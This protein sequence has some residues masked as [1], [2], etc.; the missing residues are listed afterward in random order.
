MLACVA[1]TGIGA[2][3]ERADEEIIVDLRSTRARART[4]KALHDRS[5]IARQR[6]HEIA[7]RRGWPIRGIAGGRSFELMDVVEGRPRYYATDN[8]AAAI[9]TG[10]D[11]VRN[12]T[13][14]NVDGSSVIVGVWDQGAVRSTHQEFGGR[15]N[16]VDGVAA[17]FHGT[18]I[19]GTIGASGVNAAALGMASATQIDSY[20]WNSDDAEMAARGATGKGKTNDVILS[21]HSY[22]LITGWIN[23]DFSGN[24]GPHWWG[25]FPEREDRGFGIYDANASSWDAIA[26]DAPHYLIFKS[27]GNDRNDNAPGGGTYYFISNGN[28]VAATYDAGTDPFSDGYD[29]GGYDTISYRGNAKNIMTVGAVNDAVS[30]GTRS[31][32]AGTMASFSCW[33]PTDDGRIKPDIVANGI[34]LFSTD[35]DNDTDYTTLSGTSMSTPNAAGSAA[36]LADLYCK[37]FSNQVIRASTLKALIIHTADDVGNAGPDYRFGW[38]LMNTKAAADLILRQTNAASAFTITEFRFQSVNSNDT[39][40]V[41]SDGSNVLRATLAWN[42][43]AGTPQTG[44]DNRTSVL[45]NDLDLRIIAPDGSTNYPFGLDVENPANVATNGDNSIDNVE[46]VIVSAPASGLYCVS[47]SHK[48]S[49]SGGRQIYSLIISGQEANDFEVASADGLQSSGNVGGPFAPASTTYTL[50]NLGTGTV[51]WTASGCSGFTAI[52][53]SNGVITSGASTTVVVSISGNANS[54]ASGTHFDQI[55][56]TDT[57]AGVSHEREVELNVVPPP[58]PDHFTWSAITSPHLTGTAFNVTLTARD[59]LNGVQTSFN[60]EIADL[61]GF[62]TAT[63][64]TIVITELLTDTPD[65]I[66]FMNV[67]PQAVEISNWQISV[68]DDDASWPAPLNFTVP[69]GTIVP[70]GTVFTLKEFKLDSGTF[71][72]FNLGVNIFWTAALRAAVL[73]RDDVDNIIDFMCAG[74]ANPAN[75]VSPVTIPAAEW[76]SAAVAG[77]QSTVS[78]YSRTGFKD[79]DDNSDWVEAS[80]TIASANAALIVPFA[81]A[82]AISP[83]ATGPFVSGVWTG[84]IAVLEPAL[85]VYLRAEYNPDV[86]GSSDRFD[87]YTEPTADLALSKSVDDPT[88]DEAQL[89]TY[90]IALTNAGPFGATGLTVSDAVPTSVTISNTTVSQGLFTNGLWTI[91]SMFAESSAT[92]TIEATVNSNTAGF[93]V[94]NTA[95]INTVNET[96][97]AAANDSAS[98]VLIVS[99]VDV[100]VS[101]TVSSATPTEGDIVVYTVAVTNSGTDPAS[102]VIVTDAVPA[103]VT[104]SNAAPAQGTFSNGVWTIGALGAA[105]NTTLEL[106]VSINPGTGESTITNVAALTAINETDLRAI[107]NTGSVTLVVQI[108]DLELTKQVDDSNPGVGQWIEY[109]VSVSN[110]GPHPATG[111]LVDD[112]LSGLSNIVTYASTGSYTIASGAWSNVSVL[113]GAVASLTVSGQVASLTLI[114]NTAQ[115]MASDQKDP[116][117]TPANGSGAED[118]QA[119]VTVTPHFVDIGV[120]KAVDIA[121]P[122]VADLVTFTLTASNAGPE[123]ATSVVVGDALPAGLIFSNAVP[124]QGAYS[125]GA[126]SVGTLMVDSNAML[127]LSAL[128]AP[129]SG[130]LSITN[131]AVLT[132]ASPPD[133]GGGNNVAAAAVDVTSVDLDLLK[134][135]DVSQP[136]EAQLITYTLIVTNQGPDAA[137]GIKISDALPAG[138]TFSNS[139]PSQ[140]TYSNDVWDAG[141]L[142]AGQGATLDLIVR[143]DAATSGTVITN[144]AAVSAIDQEDGNVTNNAAQALIAVT[145]V[146]IGI[147]KTVNDPTPNEGDLITYTI[148]AS[149]LGTRAG[150]GIVVTDAVPS[151]VTFSSATPSQGTFSNNQWSLGTLAPG[152][153]ATLTLDVTVDPDTGNTTITNVAALTAVSPVDVNGANNTGLVAIAVQEADLSL[154]KQVNDTSPSVGDTIAYTVVV[155]NA[156]PNAAAELRIQDVLSGL[157][158]VVSAVSTGIY[159]VSSGIWSNVS[160]PADGTASLVISGQVVS[161]TIITNTAEVVSVEQ[162]DPDSTPGNGLEAEDD[163]DS[164]VVTPRYVDVSISKSVSDSSPDEGDLVDYSLIVSNAGPSATT[165]LVIED[166]LPA[167]VTLSNAV[168][169]HGTY[170]NGSWNVGALPAQSNATLTIGATVDP[171][172]GASSITNVA[173]VTNVAPHDL[174]SGNNTDLA[175]LSVTLVDLALDK[176]VN[177]ETPDEGDAIVFTITLTNGGPDEAS[178]IEVTDALP[179]G[180]TLSNAVPSQGTFTNDAWSA[181]ALAAGSSATLS[182]TVTVD[183]GTGGSFITNSAAVTGRDQADSNASNDTAAAVILVGRADLVVS[184][185]A[186]V[187]TANAGDPVVFSVVVSNTGPHDAS[188]ISIADILPSGL[189][190]N[191]STATLGNYG[192]GTWSIDTLH[193][194]SNATLTL[195]AIVNAGTAGTTITNVATRAASTPT[196]PDAGNDSAEALVYVPLVD[197]ALNN[198]VNVASTNQGSVVVFSILLTNAGPHSAS[199]IVVADPAP[200]GLSFSNVVAS[201][202]T[203]SNGAWSAGT[204]AAGSNA[205][206]Q[207]TAVVS[208][209]TSD[210]TITNV[211]SVSAVDQ[212][213]SNIS[214]DTAQAALVVVAEAD[215]RL[216]KSGPASVTAGE[217]VQYTLSITNAGPDTALNVV[218]SD[219]LPAGVTPAG[220][221]ITN[222]GTLAPGA[223]TSLVIHVDAL[224]GTRAALTNTASAA[225]DTFDPAA[226]NNVAVAIS[227]VVVVADLEIDKQGVTNAIAGT[228]IVYTLVI[229]NRGPSDADSAQVIDRLPAGVSPNAPV[230]NGIG[231]LA[232]GATTT[233]TV[234]VTIDA[235]ATGALTNVA[236]V[237]GGAAD[238]NALNNTNALVT[239]LSTLADL[240]L[241]KTTDPNAIAGTPLVYTVTVTNRGPSDASNVTVVDT[242]PPGVTP[243]G[244]VTNA[245]GALPAGTVTSIVIQ[246]AVDSGT[247]GEI[248]NVAVVSSDVPDTNTADNTD[249]AVTAIDGRA[250]LAIS[251][252]APTNVVAGTTLN[253]TLSITNA[254]PSDAAGIQVVDLLPAGALPQGAQTNALGPLASGAATSFVIQVTVEAGGSGILTNEAFVFSTTTDTNAL[255]DADT[256]VTA[257]DP[258]ADLEISKTA[259]ANAVAGTDLAYMITVSNRGPSVALGIVVVD[260]LPAGLVISGP[261]TNVLG[262]LGVGSTTGFALVVAIDAATLGPLTNT[263][264]VLA[265][266]ADTNLLNNTAAAVSAVSSEA[267]LLLTKTGPATVNAGAEMTYTIVVSNRGPSLV[268]DAT[269]VETPPAGAALAGSLTNLLGSLAVNGTTS[270]LVS[271][272]VDQGAAGVLTNRADV[273]S[274]ALDTNLLDNGDTATSLIYVKIIAGAG[275]NGSIA[276]SGT[277]WV[278]S[279]GATNFTIA[280]D[281]FYHIVTIQINDITLTELTRLPLAEI[282]WSNITSAGT[283]EASFSENL[284]TNSTPEWWLN[285]FLGITNGFDLFA[286]EDEDGDGALAWEEFDAN[287]DPTN[288]LSVLVITGI[289]ETLDGLPILTWKSASNRTY[290]VEYTTNLPAGFM[291][292]TNGLPTTPPLNTHT[293]PVS[294]ARIMFR[295]LVE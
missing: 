247:L 26:H 228:P 272:T 187:S 145:F 47:V 183:G 143:V 57:A 231:P 72:S 121:A 111:V 70:A 62:V 64:S 123:V 50:I 12:S 185:S 46:Q 184:K 59:I 260:S 54:L 133:A 88:P 33:G 168:A 39:Y 51:N 90:T 2:A 149:N 110:V 222:I 295:V 226:S 163:Q 31:P 120:S 253:Y 69:N 221:I 55:L 115:I 95:S 205:T 87:V 118:D 248:T 154:T 269:V 17:H 49:L 267:D 209:G 289:R 177:N 197:L 214:N 36:L 85:Q 24:N 201:Q 9:S 13:P 127:T 80:D 101:K 193:A 162:G 8:V 125:N 202:G 1:G 217:P 192:A 176:T 178:S 290:G 236:Y 243:S 174:D 271:V 75:I 282:I 74:G 52:A 249:G 206:L 112:M 264:T 130:G 58:P 281:S 188:A 263:A 211:A 108:A 170:S 139:A 268:T 204:L 68:Y 141:S 97:P 242:L 273:F 224:S 137:T 15:V 160:L 122:D 280:G 283:I 30:A 261:V 161:L 270:I 65:A 6:A 93:V 291:G 56:F 238:T 60:N 210:S 126:W 274:S 53:P 252:T 4:V 10:A 76:S 91:G 98:A 230:T 102:G 234:N 278:A 42:D 275:I 71:P 172:S 213:D 134:T 147:T 218:V 189:L 181:G 138:V 237:D 164:V 229:T 265:L 3:E 285:Q 23:G 128:V 232:A 117:S 34:S 142:P 250:D 109:I 92:L 239:S 259:A 14:Y 32:A 99:H 67:S 84:S 169:S 86:V 186:D 135:V 194:N 292:L 66:E 195:N 16:N 294:G 131:V 77:Q 81:E 150:S 287:T 82:I 153:N 266:T 105:S 35:S 191:G 200:A 41:A 244:A 78:T 258:V 48:G 11:L 104:I 18:H 63:S 233:L 182:L 73:V 20:D 27:A 276:P 28:W 129:G 89:V 158:N 190:T 119:S 151:G 284:A 216:A 83:T 155:S 38:G 180:L 254:G 146:D 208:N 241:F 132:N 156:G 165:A 96:D 246:V 171:G 279:G 159:D 37:A 152:T 235:D 198:A 45:V 113:A 148:A 61:R 22:G 256:A 116:D 40:Y 5:V 251:K 140:G 223:T 227:T 103:G 199:G 173:T 94:T 166:V 7:N 43:P 19:G 257:V 25:V 212:E 207:I 29:N 286:L 21:N 262:S 220:P 245:L 167:G 288:K 136:D 114:T 175:A 157:S 203:Y 107:N 293:S 277:V 255:N 219:V 215:I 144:S 179:A 225:S 44:L 124:S 79:H 106:T 196:D 240:T 100:R